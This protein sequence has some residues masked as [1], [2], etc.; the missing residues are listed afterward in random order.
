MSSARDN[1]SALET[2]F[3]TVEIKPELLVKEKQFEKSLNDFYRQK[4]NCM[5]RPPL[6]NGKPINLYKLYTVVM[7]NGGW[8][9][10][11]NQD[12]WDQIA[13][14]M[15]YSENISMIDNG[16][17]LIYMRYLS[18]YEEFHI[19][20]D[21]DDHDSDIFG[22]KTKSKMYF[23]FASG[24]C[25]VAFPYRDKKVD[26][27]ENEYAK[28]VKSLYSG[29]PNEVDFAFN[30][31][32]LMSHPGPYVL[33]LEKCPFLLNLLISHAGVYGDDKE[34]QSLAEDGWKNFCNHEFGEFWANSGI[35]DEQILEYIPLKAL[36]KESQI[37]ENGVF[38]P[39][40]KFDVTNSTWF[41]ILQVIGLLRN[42]SFECHNVPSMGKSDIL[43]K[44]LCVCTASKHVQLVNDALDILSNIGNEIDLIIPEGVYCNIML[45]KVIS[46]CLH[47]DDKNKV[48]HSLDIIAALCQNEKNEVVC[49]E[50]MDPLMLNR[51]F[52]L[53]TVRDILICI[54]TLETLYQ[55]TLKLLIVSYFS[56]L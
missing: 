18:K 27:F 51:I 11:S 48:I 4:W 34:I 41:R 16:I 19:L 31:L 10:V 30:I 24:D 45:L 50:F 9:K 42:L 14:E 49:T 28:I 43:I 46:D 17:K 26:F 1:S 40:I 2:Y 7:S 5:C 8:F 32:T 36:K 37:F 12:K 29:L 55:V 21:I 25:P 3:K 20:G 56:Y 53:S 52:Q 6:I 47:S 44:F 39:A 35:E 13:E 54:H 15:G 23:N 38:T 22:A 33:K